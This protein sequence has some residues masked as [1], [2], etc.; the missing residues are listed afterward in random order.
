MSEA[1]SSIVKMISQKIYAAHLLLRIRTNI[2]ASRMTVAATLS[3][4]KRTCCG[5]SVLLPL[6]KI[7]SNIYYNFKYRNAF[8]LGF[9]FSAF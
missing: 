9:P 5:N 3:A 4:L 1:G 8:Y 6:V 7:K 2:A